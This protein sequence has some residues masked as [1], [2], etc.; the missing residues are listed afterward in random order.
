MNKNAGFTLI[1]LLVVVLIIGILAAVALP[2]YNKAVARARYR[3][4][5]VAATAISQAQEVYYLA[6]GTYA[7][8]YEDLDVSLGEPLSIEDTEA[9]GLQRQKIT[10][11]WGNC[12]VKSYQ[13]MQQ[14]SSVYPGVPTY[15]VQVGVR[16][17]CEAKVG[18]SMGNKICQSETG[19]TNP[20]S[21]GG[22]NY[23]TY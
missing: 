11:E 22:V 6:N 17:Q 23:Y 2:Q 20:L 4:L 8:K 15:D 10:F 1:E 12:K 18:D 13:A 14:C 19:V 16:R 9:E 21:D 5:V 3:Q 7:Y